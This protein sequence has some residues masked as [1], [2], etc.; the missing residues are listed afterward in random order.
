MPKRKQRRGLSEDSTDAKRKKEARRGPAAE[1]SVQASLDPAGRTR[2]VEVATNISLD[3]DP[4]ECCEGCVQSRNS[5]G[6]NRSPA[7][8]MPTQLQV[9]SQ[10]HAQ[11]PIPEHS[12]TSRD[13]EQV[14]ENHK[15]TPAPHQMITRLR[16]AHMGQ[17]YP[18]NQPVQTSNGQYMPIRQGAACMA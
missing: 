1:H 6:Q 12:T 11:K 13:Q 18:P 2:D 14:Y 17:D 7:H 9:P 15:S 10:M 5:A 8:R 3:G 4:R 16:A